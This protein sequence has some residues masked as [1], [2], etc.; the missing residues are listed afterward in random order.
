[1]TFAEAFEALRELAG[2]RY[3]TLSVHVGQHFPG[4]EIGFRWKAYIGETAS[5]AKDSILT[6]DYGGVEEAL[7]EIRRRLGRDSARTLE[8]IGDPSKVTS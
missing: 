7:G 1:M 2:D 3:C 5:L 4:G 8:T 6:D